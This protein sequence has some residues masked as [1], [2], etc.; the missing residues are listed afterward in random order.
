[1]LEHSEKLIGAIYMNCYFNREGH[2]YSFHVVPIEIS[3]DEVDMPQFAV[4]HPMPPH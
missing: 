3:D 2:I 1:M 4:S